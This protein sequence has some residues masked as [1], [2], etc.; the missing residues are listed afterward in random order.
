MESRIWNKSRIW[1][2]FA[3]DRVVFHMRGFTVYRAYLVLIESFPLRWNIIGFGFGFGLSGVH[4]S[5]LLDVTNCMHEKNIIYRSI[6][7]SKDFK[8]SFHRTKL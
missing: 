6:F 4:I 7:L 5:T 1:N 2:T 3:A 8:V